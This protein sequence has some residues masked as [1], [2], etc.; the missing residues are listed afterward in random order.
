MR[1]FSYQ[2]GGAE[3][4]PYGLSTAMALDPCRVQQELASPAGLSRA[5]VS[6][7]YPNGR[8][9]SRVGDGP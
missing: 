9:T 5:S 8:A 2:V 1:L 7:L 4:R 3:R 6:V